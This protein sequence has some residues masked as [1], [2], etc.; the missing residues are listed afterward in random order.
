MCE[1]WC[2]ALEQARERQCCRTIQLGLRVQILGT[3]LSIICQ[4]R[5][6]MPSDTRVF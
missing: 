5:I 6:A 3:S 4:M 1:D 2:Q